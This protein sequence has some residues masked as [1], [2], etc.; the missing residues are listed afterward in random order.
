MQV[1]IVTGRDAESR[2]WNG[3]P[4]GWVVEWGTYDSD[5]GGYLEARIAYSWERRTLVPH[6]MENHLSRSS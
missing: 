1:G 3:I 5:D 6:S 2:T 4:T